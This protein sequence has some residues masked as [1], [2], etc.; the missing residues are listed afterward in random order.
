MRNRCM[1][2][3]SWH[4][5]RTS[6][7]RGQVQRR[8]GLRCRRYV[9]RRHVRRGGA[10]R[11]WP[12]LCDNLR[13]HVGLLVSRIS[14]HV[15]QQMRASSQSGRC[16]HLLLRPGV[17]GV[18]QGQ[19]SASCDRR[20]V[21]GWDRLPFRRVL[22]G[23]HRGRTVAQQAAQRGEAAGVGHGHGN[24]ENVGGGAR[25]VG[26]VSGVTCSP[27]RAQYRHFPPRLQSPPSLGRRAGLPDSARTYR[28][29]HGV[30]CIC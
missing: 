20:A 21:H 3:L 9:H 12:S 4:L 29:K 5:S 1:L 10:A 8:L 27:H 19:M 6:R 24:E 23:G 25:T 26:D 14:Q 16:L 18:R 7:T 28:R 15:T 22:P 17:V 30:E 13:L 2:G 11:T